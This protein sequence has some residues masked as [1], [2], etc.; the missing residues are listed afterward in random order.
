LVA[1]LC[2]LALFILVVFIWNLVMAP[3]HMASE[4]EAALATAKTQEK[5][6]K[7]QVS[8]LDETIQQLREP[9]LAVVFDPMCSGCL[10][11]VVPDRDDT[12]FGIW[13]CSPTTTIT[14]VHVFIDSLPPLLSGGKRE[15]GWAGEE[16]GPGKTLHPTPKSGHV[17]VAF[18]SKYRNSYYVLTTERPTLRAE[19]SY[20]ARVLVEGYNTP[21]ILHE[22]QINPGA[23]PPITIA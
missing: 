14:D 12:N 21:P 1:G 22:I 19:S 10:Y 6:L 13:N 17:H 2:A 18:L 9:K 3:V 23:T 15:L 11:R 8:A 20:T 7:G 4:Q 16:W 5:R